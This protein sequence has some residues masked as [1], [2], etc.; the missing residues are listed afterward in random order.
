MIHISSSSR[1]P[2][3]TKTAARIFVAVQLLKAVSGL[4]IGGPVARAMAFTKVIRILGN[5][6]R[7]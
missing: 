2:R 4:G 7:T 1:L 5:L 3:W 6:R